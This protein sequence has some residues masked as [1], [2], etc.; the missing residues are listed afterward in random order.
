MRRSEPLITRASKPNGQSLLPSAPVSGKEVATHKHLHNRPKKGD[1]QFGPV[2]E[3]GRP[4]AKQAWTCQPCHS[5]IRGY[6]QFSKSQID[7]RARLR[8]MGQVEP[9]GCEDAA[10][11]ARDRELREART[12]VDGEL[13]VLVAEQQLDE[14]F[15]TVARDR[16]M[17]SLD[18]VDRYGRPLYEVIAA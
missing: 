11:I 2:C 14:R 17:V 13:A 16:W 12:R 6:K 7:R 18:D 4:K 8:Y 10:L 1:P 9:V 5:R 15:A 3:C